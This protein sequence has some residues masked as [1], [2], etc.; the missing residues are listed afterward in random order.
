M[1]CLAVVSGR[2]SSQILAVCLCLLHLSY[3]L[4]CLTKTCPAGS[5]LHSRT[6]TS[7]TLIWPDSAR[8]CR[9]RMTFD[10]D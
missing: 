1:D 5:A 4:N 3:C 6:T 2:T 9:G 8:T 7:L 10:F